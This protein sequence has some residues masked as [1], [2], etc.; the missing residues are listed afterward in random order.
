MITVAIVLGLVLLVGVA[1]GDESGA[2][3]PVEVTSVPQTIPQRDEATGPNNPVVQQQQVQQAPPGPPPSE[4]PD[5]ERTVEA[6]V[7]DRLAELDATVEALVER[8]LA[9]LLAALAPPEPIYWPTLEDYKIANRQLAYVNDFIPVLIRPYENF[10]SL[11]VAHECLAG[12]EL[13]SGGFRSFVENT[14]LR[15]TQDGKTTFSICAGSGSHISDH[16]LS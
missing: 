14:A 4:N 11:Y 9:E 3:V 6:I 16:Q 5:L 10:A 7:E 15:K 8:R 13:T 2:Q 12:E 1:C